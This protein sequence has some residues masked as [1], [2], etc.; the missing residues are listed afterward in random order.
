MRPLLKRTLVGVIGAILALECAYLVAANVF[1]NTDL[2][3]KTINRKPEKFQLAWRSAWSLYPGMVVLHDAQVRGRSRRMEWYAR[4]DSVTASFHLRPL[5]RRTVHL[6]SVKASGVEYRQRRRLLPG[7]TSRA[8]LSELP[9]IPEFLDTPGGP[10]GLPGSTRKLRSPWTVIADGITCDLDE[11]WIDRFRL[12]GSLR[13]ETPMSL[14]VRGPMEFPRVRL[15]MA[16]GDLWAGEGKIFQALG[17]DI[18]ATLHPFIA[19]NA[20][21]LGFFRYLSGHFVLQSD[22]ASLF[23]LEAYFRKTP[24]LRFNDWAAGRMELRL[25]HGRLQ[26]GSTLQIANDNVDMTFLD[27]RLTGK[28]RIAGIVE[29][30]GGTAQSRITALLQDFQLVPMGSAQPL[31]RGRSATLVASSTALDLS[32]PFTDLK[33][34]FDLPQ[35]EILDLPFYNSMIP[36][37]SR[38]RLLTGT[39]T[40]SYHLEGSQEER[41]LHGTI[42]LAVKK[43]AA[44][45]ENYVMRGDFTL[46]TLLRQSSPKELLFDVSGTRLDLHTDGPEW[47]AVITFPKAN[48][49]FSEPL[50][51]EAAVQLAMLDTRPLVVMYDA[52]KGVPNWLEKMMIIENIKGVATLDVR[53][54]RVVVKDL[55]VTGKGLHALADLVL[56]KGSREGILYL[57]FHGLSLGV[58]L[59]KGGRDLKVIRPLNWFQQQRDRRRPE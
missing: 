23:F 13:V 55:D 31:A 29:E 48:M 49:R 15:T 42:D 12:D 38:F 22:S 14:V 44:R 34:V 35:A 50:K 39:G 5:L 58:E 47:S 40:L 41:S 18:D 20:R 30:T 36:P 51:I 6:K 16:S 45:F 21:G 52:L 32:N 1:L 10:R 7:E 53:R 27:R 46:K 37:G 3:P 19:R 57:R 54:D 11:L 8:P 26:P 25:D 17:L 4:L 2:A 59:K 9:P 33:V 24:W 43:A 28:G 56:G